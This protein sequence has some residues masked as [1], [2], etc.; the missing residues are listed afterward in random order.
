MELFDECCAESDETVNGH[1]LHLLTVSDDNI[2]IAVLSAAEIVPAHYSS[3]ERVAGIL[4]RFGKEAAAQYLTEKIPTAKRSRSGDLGEILATEYIRARTDYSAPISRFI[5]KDHRQMAMRGDDVIGIIEPAENH[6][7]RFLKSEVKSRVTVSTTVVKEA[8]STLDDYHGLPAPHALSFVSD[9]LR[10]LGQADL[11]DLIDKAQLLD[12]ID[13]NQVEHLL[14]VFSG[15]S[16][17]N[18]LKNDLTTY[19]G[20]IRQ[21]SAGLRVGQHQLFIAKVYE[22]VEATDDT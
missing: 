12:G 11:S 17:E 19:A 20:P 3:V 21:L 13:S 2:E 8:R 15:N 7:I 14:F 18:F 6:P 16:S 4:E 5:W 22:T 1:K 9:R 10:E